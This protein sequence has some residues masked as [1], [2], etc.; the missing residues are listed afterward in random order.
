MKY[1]LIFGMYILFLLMLIPNVNATTDSSV[2][3]RFSVN[4]K[5]FYLE[6][7]LEEDEG[8]EIFAVLNVFKD[9]RIIYSFDGT[10]MEMLSKINDINK[11]E[12]QEEYYYPNYELSGSFITE[13]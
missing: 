8:I 13:T 10:I 12:H 6:V 9:R 11:E 7:F 3:I 2:V 1:K 5:N 4:N